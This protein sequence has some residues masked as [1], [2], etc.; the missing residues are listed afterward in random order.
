MSVCKRYKHEQCITIASCKYLS[1]K[2]L[3]R[4]T[5]CLLLEFENGELRV[6]SQ[7][8]DKLSDPVYRSELSHFTECGLFVTESCVYVSVE[9]IENAKQVMP[10]DMLHNLLRFIVN[11]IM[12]VSKKAVSEWFGT[13]LLVGIPFKPILFPM[14]EKFKESISGEQLLTLLHNS[15]FHVNGNFDRTCF[16][17]L[18]FL[19]YVKF[20]MSTP[21]K[22]NDR[23]SVVKEILSWKGIYNDPT[24]NPQIVKLYG[25]ERQVV[26]LLLCT[27]RFRLDSYFHALPMDI[28]RFHL[29]PLLCWSLPFKIPFLF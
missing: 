17:I 21:L 15:L 28:L 4:S 10:V 29:I 24:H 20:P 1:F 2:N 11:D 18:V 8:W 3:P 16:C 22:F 7:N 12:L 26:M 23:W 5:S 9:K 25:M 13:W 19:K 6:L 27:K 14:F